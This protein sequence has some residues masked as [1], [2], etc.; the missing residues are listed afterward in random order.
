VIGRDGDV[1]RAVFEELH[2]RA[3]D[4]GNCAERRIV[5][6]EAAPIAFIDSRSVK[7]RSE[8]GVQIPDSIRVPPDDVA[9]HESEIP[10]DR[11]IV[12]YCT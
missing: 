12:T 11:S 8:S 10:K 7:S 6:R 2:D 9:K 3:E 1:R 5:L 4:T